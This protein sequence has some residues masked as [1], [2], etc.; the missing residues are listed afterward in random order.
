MQ[1]SPEEV[2][3][4]DEAKIKIYLIKNQSCASARTHD[5]DCKTWWWKYHAQGFIF[6]FIRVEGKPDVSKCLTILKENLNKILQNCLKHTA[7]TTTNCFRSKQ[8]HVLERPSQSKD[9]SPI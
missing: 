9:L 6:I 2:F 3:H 7:R 8:I 1:I 4:L 5:S